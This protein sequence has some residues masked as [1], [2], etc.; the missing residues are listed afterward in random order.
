MMDRGACFAYSWHFKAI[1]IFE[2]LLLL[3]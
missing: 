2:C 1:H 3:K